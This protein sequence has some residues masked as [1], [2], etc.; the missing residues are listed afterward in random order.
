MVYLTRFAVLDWGPM[1]L[2]EAKGAS[3]A[4]AGWIVAMFEISGILGTLFSG[5][6]TDRLAGGRAPRIC[7][8]MMLGAAVCMSVFW[9]IPAGA[10]PCLYIAALSGAGFCADGR[11]GGQSG[12]ETV[13]GNGHRLHIALLLRERPLLRLGHGILGRQDGRMV[14]PVCFRDWSDTHRGGLVRAPVEYET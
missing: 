2:K 13:C 8:F 5:W 4:S 14:C 1:L 12:D 3:L 10:S 6:A 9:L 11:D 7:L